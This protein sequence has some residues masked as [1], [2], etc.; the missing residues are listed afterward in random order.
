MHFPADHLGST[1]LTT[2]AAG[3]VVA[4]RR[5]HPYGE[6][7]Y[8]AGDVQTD[9]GYTGQRDVPGTGL[10]YYHA[11]YYHPALGRF[12]SAD[13]IVPE[14]GNPQS[15]NR[16]AYV[17]NNPLKYIDPSGHFPAPNGIIDWFKQGLNGWSLVVNPPGITS[18]RADMP[19]TSDMTDWLVDQIVSNAQ[20]NIVAS[21]K[22]HWEN[23]EVFPVT[24][25]QH[26]MANQSQLS[27]YEYGCYDCEIESQTNCTWVGRYDEFIVEFG[28]WMIPQRMY[29]D[30]M[31]EIICALDTHVGAYFDDVSQD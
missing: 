28:A 8:V 29:L 21:I 3:D 12:V 14:P 9:F 23:G 22:S 20:S 5:Y 18:P 10:M 30:D 13:T 7:R 6:E 26:L 11:R 1:S 25:C 17:T 19:P 16:Y 2:D 31:Q 24:A 27:C 15:L 4:R